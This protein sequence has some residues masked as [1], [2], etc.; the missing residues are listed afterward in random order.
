VRSEKA[1]T[2]AECH[3]TYQKAWYKRNPWSTNASSKR[4]KQAIRDMIIKEKSKPCVDCDKAY[5]YYV[6][7]FDHVRGDKKFGLGEAA[8]K[9][10]S[11]Q[12]IQEEIDKCD[13][14]CANCH[15]ERTFKR[16]SGIDELVESPVFETGVL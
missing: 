14:V 9:M 4:R 10:R 3:N 15:R 13:L 7:D 16:Y 8:V 2:C 11:L 6:M 5:P 12:S 1:S